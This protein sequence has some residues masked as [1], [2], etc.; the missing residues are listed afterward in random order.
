MELKF[1]GKKRM[2]SFNLSR[3]NKKEAG[4]LSK[5]P[6]SDGDENTDTHLDMTHECALAKNLRHLLKLHHLNSNQLANA[7]NLPMMTIRRIASG[8]TADP[9]ISTVKLIADYFKIS[10]DTLISNASEI[11]THRLHPSVPIFVPILDWETAG[12]MH[13]LQELD[14]SKWKEWQPVSFNDNVPLGNHAFA[15]ES[16]PFMYPRFPQGTLFIIDPD[17]PPTDGDLVLMKI[18]H[19]HELTLKELSIDP[20][21]WNLHSITNSSNVLRYVETEHQFRGV[22]LLSMLY[23]RK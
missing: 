14:L 19:N 16:R 2:E 9:R 13:S 8:E 11:H 23:N 12:K 1:D 20:P 21:D 3:V 7:L 22:V 17:A 5:N 4:F 6:L 18:N 10:I 15:L